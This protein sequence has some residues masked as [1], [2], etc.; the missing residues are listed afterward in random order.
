MRLLALL[1]V[2]LLPAAAFAEVVEV[3]IPV[4]EVTCS[5]DGSSSA[6]FPDTGQ[7]YE[8]LASGDL[9]MCFATTCPEPAGQH[10]VKGNHGLFFVRAGTPL[11][12]RSVDG[13]SVLQFVPVRVVR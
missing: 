5:L 13:A 3:S 6:T 8:L 9:S 7:T 2:A 12:C 4:V 1:T 11:S 10:R